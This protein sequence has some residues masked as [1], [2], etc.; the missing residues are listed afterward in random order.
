MIKGKIKKESAFSPLAIIVLLAA[1]TQFVVLVR[2]SK[3]PDFLPDS[4]DMAFY[5]DWGRRIANGQWTDGKAFYGLPGYAYLLGAVY[6]VVGFD[7]FTVAYTVGLLQVGIFALTAGLIYQMAIHS[8]PQPMASA[9]PTGD[10]RLIGLIAALGWI[11][12]VP[13]QTFAAVLMP[14]VWSIFA[15][16]TCVI[17]LLRLRTAS[18]FFPWL[19]IGLGMGAVSLMVATILMLT[20]LVLFAVWKKLDP[21]APWKVR[22]PKV[23]AAA[24]VLAAGILL[25][26]APASLHNHLIAHEPVMLSAHSGVNFWVGNNPSANGYPA[27]PPGFRASQNGMLKDSISLA[28]TAAGHPLKRWEVSVFWSEKAHNYIRNNFWEWIRLMGRKFSNFWNTF[29]YDDVCTIKPLQDQGATWPGLSF[30]LVAALGLAGLLI[31]GWQCA[32]ARWISAAVLLHMAALMPVFVTER[33]RLAAVPGLLILASW[34]MVSLWTRLNQRQWRPAAL[35]IFCAGA[36]AFFVS[37]PRLDPGLWSIDHYES[38][39]HATAVGDLDRAERD[40]NVSLSYSPTSPE[41]NFAMGN[42]W[43]KREDRGQAKLY[44]RRALELNPR[45]DG[46]LNNLCVLAIEEK[47]WKLAEMF[48]TGSLQVEQEDAKRHFMLARIRVELGDL[49]GARNA[50]ATALRLKPEQ[51][52]FLELQRTIDAKATPSSPS[53]P[54]TP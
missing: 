24:L 37:A 6:T 27:M 49:A 32:S 44:Y 15:Y 26:S 51:R 42:L 20:P 45:H 14:T 53:I 7:P 22:A 43:L 28:E 11:F 13:A 25:G 50:L 31:S 47:R 1:I 38:G 12:F 4:D 34:W 33:Y 39:I 18:V 41:V 2:F 21:S 19:W 3:C 36:T 17:C 23:L 5:S 9:Q 10:P 46:V 48:I 29:Q 16:W 30:G 35:L 40:L 8:F 54:S 52:E